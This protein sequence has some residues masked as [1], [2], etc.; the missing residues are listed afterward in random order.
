[1]EALRQQKWFKRLKSKLD[2]ATPGCDPGTLE[3]EKYLN[4][5]DAFFSPESV[6][7]KKA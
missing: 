3:E 5:K 6:T 1:L 4:D 2:G 7:S